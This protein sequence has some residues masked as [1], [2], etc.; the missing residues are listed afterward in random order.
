[1][2]RLSRLLII[3]GSDAGISAALRARE[4]NPDFDVTVVVADRFPNY[5]ICGLPF[6]LSGEVADWHDLA[7]RTAEDIASKGIEL[8]LDR[9]AQTI[10]PTAKIVTIADPEGQTQQLTYDRLIVGT[11]AV[12]TRP[13]IAGLDLPGVYLLR[14]MADSFA[15]H[16]HLTTHKPESVVIIGGGYIGLEMADAFTHQNLD[17][18]VVEHSATVM[19]T[20][21]SSLGQAIAHE[22]Q[23]H[24][25]KVV[26]DVAIETIEQQGTQ[27]LVKG[28]GFEAKADL[29]LVS[30]GVKPSTYLA[31]TAG[32]ATGIEGAIAVNRKMETNIPDIYAAGDCIETWHRLLNRYTYLPLGTTAHKQGRIAGE[33]AVEGDR[34]F[35]GVLG[36]QVVKVFDLAIARTGLR[37]GE[38][39]EAGFDPYTVELETWSHKAYY[40]GARELHI[41]ITGDRQTHRLLGAQIV[42]HYH[43]EVAKR[44]DI[45]A[46]ALFHNM[47][48]EQLDDLDLSYTPPFSSPW[49]PIQM[50][51]QAWVKSQQHCDRPIPVRA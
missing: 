3:G 31:T 8:L 2:P 6:F 51:A 19:K 7:H 10:D 26:N 21:D 14:S 1:M 32:I 15:V 39:V 25:V 34:E 44:I 42:G 30:V 23:R 28:G 46:A 36:T 48:M 4:V 20:V 37:D 13:K 50:S 29:V 22:L 41:R 9:T 33:N 11:G 49:D 43:A 18:T 12:P 38:A 5:S 47:T 17:V 40:P 24:G 16:Q 27:L 35:A 45:F